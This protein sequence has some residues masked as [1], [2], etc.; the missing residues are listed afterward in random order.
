MFAFMKNQSEY[1][2][3]PLW[4]IAQSLSVRQYAQQASRRGNTP[5]G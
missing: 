3:D 1:Q 2:P 4:E 5:P